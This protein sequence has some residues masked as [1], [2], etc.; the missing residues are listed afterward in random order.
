MAFC[1]DYRYRSG[2]ECELF[3]RHLCANPF[4]TQSQSVAIVATK[5]HICLKTELRGKAGVG[6]VLNHIF[7]N[8]ACSA[9]R[10]RLALREGLEL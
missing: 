3:G 2:A 9:V 6:R 8:A 10:E 1:T 5:R 7:F 4:L